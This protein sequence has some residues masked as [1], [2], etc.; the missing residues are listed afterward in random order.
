MHLPTQVGESGVPLTGQPLTMFLQQAAPAARPDYSF[1]MM[2][3]AIFLIFYFLLIRP[4]QRRQ[5][6]H[7]AQIKAI[8]RGDRVV[9]A[10]GL[11]GKVTGVADDVLTIEIAALKSGD[12]VRVQVQRSKIE[13]VA[14]GEKSE[15]KG[16]EK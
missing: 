13:S 6:D 16:G 15:D 1:F 11:H 8:D 2:M 9:T 7:E 10:G 4:Q 5:K 14:K 3:G 12:R